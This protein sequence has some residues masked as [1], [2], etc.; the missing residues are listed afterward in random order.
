[1]KTPQIL[2]IKIHNNKTSWKYPQAALQTVFKTLLVLQ[3]FK[4]AMDRPTMC[5]NLQLHLLASCDA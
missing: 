5:P 3:V 4:P 2:A 1:M